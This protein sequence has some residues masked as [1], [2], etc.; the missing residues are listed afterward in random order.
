[1][2][3]R[4]REGE[5]YCVPEAIFLA[6]IDVLLA[7][8]F[9]LKNRKKLLERKQTASFNIFAPCVSMRERERERER[10]RGRVG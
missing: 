5:E 9:C 3:E 8:G 10:K 4:E 1:M 7:F 2:R 6:S